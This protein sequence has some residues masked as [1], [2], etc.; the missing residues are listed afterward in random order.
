VTDDPIFEQPKPGLLAR[1]L[2][3]LS[4][5]KI[6][7][8]TRRSEYLNLHVPAKS[9]EAVRAALERWLAGHGVTTALTTEDTGDGKVRIRA[10]LGR[11]D[12]AKVDFSSDAIQSELQDVLADA[13][14]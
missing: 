12:A 13:V 10:K 9:S 1:L 14:S 4:S 11:E 5:R 8:K 3:G 2:G 6:D 7:V